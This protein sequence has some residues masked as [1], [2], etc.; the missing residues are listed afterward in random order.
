MSDQKPDY[1]PPPSMDSSLFH[2]FTDC[3][4]ELRSFLTRR[5]GCA[6]AAADIVQD[7]YVRLA[8]RG[9]HQ[10]HDNP[11]ALVFRVAAN[12]ATDHNRHRRIQEK[13]DGG[14]VEALHIASPIPSP[15][16]DLLARQEEALLKEAIAELP[17]TRRMVFL[18]RMSQELSYSQIA[19]RV[20]ISVSAVEKH[21]HKAI[22]HCRTYVN[23]HRSHAHD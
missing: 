17:K 14:T 22:I 11:R 5:L 7:T 1:C 4:K 16:A 10:S 3:M 12:L 2:V 9:N 23:Q 20:G 15:D 13:F 8:L 18:L 6:D 19:Q 21:M